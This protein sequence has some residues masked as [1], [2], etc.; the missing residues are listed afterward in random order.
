MVFFVLFV[1]FDLCGLWFF[2]NFRVVV[3]FGFVCGLLGVGFEWFGMISLIKRFLKNYGR[4]GFRYI[5]GMVID[6]IG[7]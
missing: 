5:V 1:W 6:G 4:C 3:G 2:G 7:R